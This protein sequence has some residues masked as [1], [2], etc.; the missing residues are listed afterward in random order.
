MEE[1]QYFIRVGKK[2]IPVD[3]SLLR[4]YRNMVRQQKYQDVKDW[5]NGLLYYD[6]W[7]SEAIHGADVCIDPGF[8]TEELAIAAIEAE[9]LWDCIEKLH[10]EYQICRLTALGYSEREIAKMNGVTKFA[11]RKR[12]LRLFQQ[13]RELFSGKNIQK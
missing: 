8:D 6:A 5:A 2:K 4:E 7:D 10:D 9:K 13:L 1:K 11:I 12:K 3:E